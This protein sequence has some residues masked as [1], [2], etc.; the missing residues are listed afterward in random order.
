MASVPEVAVLAVITFQG[1]ELRSLVV[2]VRQASLLSSGKS[3]TK[4]VLYC[5]TSGTVIEWQDTELFAYA[6]PS[7]MLG[8]LPVTDEQ[9][10][11]KETL[12]C[13]SN[14]ELTKIDTPQPSSGNDWDGAERMLASAKVTTVERQETEN[15]CS[16]VDAAA[17][18]ARKALTGD[19]LRAME[20]ASA[21]ADA[22]AFK[23]AGYPKKAVPL[24]VS[25]WAVKGRTAQ[26]AADDILGKSAEF[27]NSLLTLRTLR[28]KAKEQIRA[29][30]AK[31]KTERAK[32]VCDA[33]ILAL[34][35][36]VGDL[37]Q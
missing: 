17:D 35:N 3:M 11:Q 20:Y 22:Q 9:W 5:R 37:S 32:E 2:R 24:S 26:E 31:G 30:V 10:V 15:L 1:L 13:V 34:R 36:V 25:A 18:S 21:A 14:D 28:L 27:N 16:R 12:H 19:P 23:D 29:Q 4:Q 6:A 7:V 8:I 33:A